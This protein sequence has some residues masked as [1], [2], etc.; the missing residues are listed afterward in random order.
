MD[1]GEL[2]TRWTVRVAMTSYALSLG[3]RLTNGSRGRRDGVARIAAAL[4]GIGCAFYIVHVTC[5]FAYFH[6]WSHAAALEHTAVRSA[7]VVGVRF[8]GGLYFNY[9]F[10]ALW[11]GDAAW[12]LFGRDG[13]RRRSKCYDLAMHGF[14]LFMVVNAVVV[15]GPSSTR[16]IG[17]VATVV[18]LALWV[19]ARKL[20]QQS[21]TPL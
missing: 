3:I 16:W 19:R 10:T 2:L 15:F 20:P 4:W 11:I 5:A 7:E 21:E 14:L 8:G 9:L 18:L 17:A 6:H 13:Y 12:M 1:T